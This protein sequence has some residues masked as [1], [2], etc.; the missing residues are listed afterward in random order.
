MTNRPRLKL[1]AFTGIWPRMSLRP[2]FAMLIAVA[3]LFAPLAIQSGNAMAMAPAADHHAQMMEGGHCGDQPAKSQ[4]SQS[5]DKSCC[6]AMCT[7]IAVAPTTPIE[8]HALASSVERP[9]LTQFSHSFLAELP[10]PPPRL[11]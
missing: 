8:P 3:M 10:T 1:A 2:L 9:S 7:A 11:A 4:D 5:D 6:V